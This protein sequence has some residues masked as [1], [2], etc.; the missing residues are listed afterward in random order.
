MRPLF[1]TQHT[2][3]HILVVSSS[4]PTCSFPFYYS[5]TPCANAFGNERDGGQEGVHGGAAGAQQNKWRGRLPCHDVH[6]RAR[7]AAAAIAT[8]TVVVI[9]LRARL[10]QQTGSTEVADV[11]TGIGSVQ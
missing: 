1:L 6:T 4:F 10:G 7:A 3:I 8:V 11:I 2:C 5:A 9:N